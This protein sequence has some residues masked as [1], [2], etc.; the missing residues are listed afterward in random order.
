MWRQVLPVLKPARRLRNST[1]SCKSPSTQSHTIA[2]EP[3]S[4]PSVFIMVV[5]KGSTLGWNG[6]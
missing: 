1:G 5:L 6:G 3:A 4:S 2:I